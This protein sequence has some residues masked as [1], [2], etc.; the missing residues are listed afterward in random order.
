M[1]R[2]AL[3]VVLLCCSTASLRGQTDTAPGGWH[4]GLGGGYNQSMY[5]CGAAKTR[6]NASFSTRNSFMVQF[7]A[8]RDLCPVAHSP[9]QRFGI[10]TQLAFK[11]QD[12]YFYYEEMLDTLVPT[13][14]EQT[15]AVL[16]WSLYPQW[17]FGDQVRLLF[18]V[19]PNL[20]YVVANRSQTVRM[21]DGERVHSEKSHSD[22]VA[23]WSLGGTLGIG[24]EIPLTPSLGLLL[25]N[26]Y[27][28]GYTSKAGSLKSLYGFYHCFDISMSAAIRY[29]FPVRRSVR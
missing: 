23:G 9:Y 4:L 21:I 15:V 24:V 29:T 3:A 2:I 26:A 13:G 18:F 11:R 14:T 17:V 22:E 8:A 27:T 10:G 16:H 28:S 1:S 5:Y 12:A 25:Q 20:E 7:S 19:G 6:L